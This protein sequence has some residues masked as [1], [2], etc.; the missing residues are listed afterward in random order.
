MSKEIP[1][2]IDRR[3]LWKYLN[4][5]ISRSVNYAHTFGIMNILIDELIKD[6]NNEKQIKIE[7]FGTLQL[8]K[9]KPRVYFHLKF[10]KK[11]KSSGKKILRFKICKKMR[12]KLAENIDLDRTFGDNYNE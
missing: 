11:M 7:N 4:I 10:R 5:K 12:D 8:I 2:S 9:T 1:L 6:L 3:V